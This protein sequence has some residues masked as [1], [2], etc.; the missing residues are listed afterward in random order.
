M[1]TPGPALGAGT[2]MGLRLPPRPL[3][4]HSRGQTRGQC[5]WQ[6]KEAL[7]AQHCPVS[8]CH[9]SL[10]TG[11]TFCSSLHLPAQPRAPTQEKPAKEGPLDHK[12]LGWDKGARRAS[13]RAD[14]ELIWPRLGEDG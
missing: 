7:Q 4:V 3:G 8:L 13:W 2:Q 12:W 11:A 10:Q 9:C 5:D 1:C 14:P 6:E